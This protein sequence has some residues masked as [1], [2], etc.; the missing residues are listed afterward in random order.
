MIF[1]PHIARIISREEHEMRWEQNL[2]TT[3]WGNRR[4]PQ[5]K[6]AISYREVVELVDGTVLCRIVPA[7]VRW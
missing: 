7:P 5:I 3:K 1:T 6:R 2:N 4:K